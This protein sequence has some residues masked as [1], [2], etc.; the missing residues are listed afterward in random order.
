MDQMNELLERLDTA[1]ASPDA[2]NYPKGTLKKLKL[3]KRVVTG[4]MKRLPKLK[5]RCVT[6]KHPQGPGDADAWILPGGWVIHV[7][8]YDQDEGFWKT[9]SEWQAATL[10]HETT[11]SSA[12]THDSA[13]F[14]P[15]PPRDVGLIEWPSIAS[16][17]DTWIF[18]GFCI[19]GVNCPPVYDE[20][21]NRASIAECPR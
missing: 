12:W 16:T 15:Y 21:D 1:I 18:G 17:Y 5:V 6:A 7:M 3:A 9:V 13:Y 2:K 4:A 19:P 11:H 20:I 10:V 14:Y 8:R